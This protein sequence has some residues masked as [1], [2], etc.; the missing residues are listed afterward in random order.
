MPKNHLDTAVIDIEQAKIEAYKDGYGRFEGF[1]GLE[2]EGF[3]LGP[4]YDSAIYANIVLPA[5]RAA[6]GYADDGPGTYTV[7]R[8]VV[9]VPKS[10]MMDDRPIEA[11]GPVPSSHILSELTNAWS[12]GA[13]DGAL[14]ETEDLDAAITA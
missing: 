12:M 13:Y 14:G 2:Q 11:E 8:E 6:A 1:D 4:F 3:D 9:V 5:M 10:S 7:E